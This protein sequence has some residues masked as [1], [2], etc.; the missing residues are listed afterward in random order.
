METGPELRALPLCVK[1]VECAVRVHDSIRVT[2]VIWNMLLLPTRWSNSKT[3][4][5]NWNCFGGSGAWWQAESKIIPFTVSFA[6]LFT[7]G[8]VEGCV[9]VAFSGKKKETESAAEFVRSVAWFDKS[10]NIC[11]SAPSGQNHV[12]DD[13]LAAI[14]WSVGAF[15]GSQNVAAEYM[16]TNELFGWT[17]FSA[18]RFKGQNAERQHLT[19]KTGFARRST[20]REAS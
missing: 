14:G 5:N 18:A 3:S 16:R 17:R 10:A 7:F 20:A 9:L 1:P 12:W 2:L 6:P 15:Q 19:M 8:G 13:P 11:F 4:L